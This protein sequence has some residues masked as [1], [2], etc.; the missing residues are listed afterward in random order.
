MRC[1]SRNL[2]DGKAFTGGG[3]IT[4]CLDCS[5]FWELY[6]NYGGI[7]GLE[8]KDVR[9]QRPLPGQVGVYVR[10]LLRIRSEPMGRRPA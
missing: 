7:G 1:G 5:S 8:D 4:G 10:R 2:Q 3:G 9:W 6:G